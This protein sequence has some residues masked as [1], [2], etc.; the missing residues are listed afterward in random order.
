MYDVLSNY[1]IKTRIDAI[2][3]VEIATAEAIDP[4]KKDPR[5]ERRQSIAIIH[6]RERKITKDIRGSPDRVLLQG[7][8]SARHLLR[9]RVSVLAA[10][11]S[12]LP[13]DRGQLAVGFRFDEAFDRPVEGF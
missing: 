9:H 8:V 3:T 10:T 2:V 4:S 6:R 5:S 1:P 12:Q 13:F 11:S 7:S